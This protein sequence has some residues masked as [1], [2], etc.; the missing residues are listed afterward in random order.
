MNLALI[1]TAIR[2]GA[3]CLNHVKVLDLVKE[4][5][6]TGKSVVRGAV[7]RDEITG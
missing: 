1:L 7:V 2:K 6:S 5:D 3:Q 4:S